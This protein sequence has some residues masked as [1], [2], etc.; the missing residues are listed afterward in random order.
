MT[1]GEVQYSSRL[2]DI[3]ILKLEIKKLQR[4]RAILARQ[5]SSVQ[6]LRKEIFHTQRYVYPNCVGGVGIA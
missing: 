6:E 5:T 4:E 3:R 2:E 1:K